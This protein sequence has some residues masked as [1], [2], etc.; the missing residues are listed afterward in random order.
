MP[1]TDK[2]TDNEHC[3]RCCKQDHRINHDRGSPTKHKIFLRERIREYP[4][5]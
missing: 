5:K 2:N 4:K 3:R 1:L